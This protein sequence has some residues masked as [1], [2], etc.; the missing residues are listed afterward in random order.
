MSFEWAPRLQADSYRQA[1]LSRYPRFSLVTLAIAA[2]LGCTLVQAA[3]WLPSSSLCLAVVMA[4]LV[5]LMR[6]RNDVARHAVTVALF[7]AWAAL[8]GARGVS[9]RLPRESEGEDVTLVGRVVDLPRRVDADTSFLF[10][11][12]AIGDATVVLRGRVRLTWYRSASP[13][14]PCERWR[15]RVRLRR[16]RGSVNPG[17]SDA[18]RVALQRGIVATGYV[19]PSRDNRKVSDSECVDGWRSAIADA[20]D[21]QLGARRARV[22]KALSVGDMRGL[23]GAD[24]DIARATGVSH[25]IAIS[26][27]HV[28]VAASG[29]VLLVRLI[30][31]AFPWLALRLPRPVVQ[32]IAGLLV[33]TGYGLL[34]GMGLP[35][36]RT[37]L[38]IAVMAAAHCLRR[39]VHGVT[40][41]ALALVAVLVASPLSVLSAGFWLS[42]AG[43]G[44]LMACVAPRAEGW[45][46]WI[47][48]LLPAQA[49]M[50]LLLLPMSLWWFGSASLAGFA[51]NLVAAPLVSFL[52]V[53]LCLA[54]SVLLPWPV[55]AAPL[56]S[57]ASGL[58]DALWHGLALVAAWPAAR[59]GVA[60]AGL[61][62]VVLAS[63]GAAWLF[64]PRGVPLRGYGSL[65]CLPLLMPPKAVPTHG[66]FHAWVLD[67]GQGL[68]VLVRT[69]SHTLVYD[70]GPAYA[71]GRDAGA[72]VVLPSITALG[73]GPVD[74][75][76]VSHGDR[77]HAGGASSIAARY[78]QALRLSGEPR[79]LA[80]PA[81]RCTAQT[82]WSWDGVVFRFIDV[83]RE[84]SGKTPGNDR[85]CVLSIEGAGGRFLLTGDISERAERRVDEDA[86]LS[87]L[88]TVSTVAHH[89]SRHSSGAGWL[90]A[91]E[92][93]LAVAS[94][95]YRNR[96]GHPHPTVVRRFEA[97][98]ARML[99]TAGSGAVR[100]DFPLRGGPRVAREWRLGER[101]YWRD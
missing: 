51:A 97:V 10:V 74:M 16:P 1:A 49:A 67:V 78:P 24:W 27:F 88:P 31:A 3:P 69:R 52:V 77:D 20:L 40:M 37:L 33:A 82:S 100:I 89:G 42:F 75:L 4:L 15:L 34:A 44:F 70:T 101:R 28:G 25:L 91:V 98:G 60:E 68:A 39:G 85:S 19:R 32:S 5:V 76:V 6:V 95:G 66:A 73:L 64:L 45:R 2:L 47:G 13:P 65:L 71:G 36:V 57:T 30:Y 56:L 86:W 87:E 38:M 12:D 11:P 63:F 17:G 94:A 48:E 22:I 50:S 72:G 26:G 41:L 54:G 99:V 46:G 23:D 35:T 93:V 80:F 92:P 79:R 61:V 21:R 7:A 53:P 90:A 8:H 62:P 59:L 29:G 83:P 18:E 81:Q 84:R 96:F 58:L 9:E 43:V 14:R 55:L